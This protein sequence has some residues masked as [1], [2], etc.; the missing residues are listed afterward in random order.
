MSATRCGLTG[1]DII[2]L[3]NRADDQD[4]ISYRALCEDRSLDEDAFLR[5]VQK[6]V[7]TLNPGA[8]PS[9]P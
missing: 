3:C 8:A 9:R 4:P 7:T 2:A 6:L 1:R 5:E